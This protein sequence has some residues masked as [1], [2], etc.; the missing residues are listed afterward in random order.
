[1]SS[2]SSVLAVRARTPSG[3]SVTAI[4]PLRQ[5]SIP[6][7]ITNKNIVV[8]NGAVASPARYV[9]ADMTVNGMGGTPLPA[10]LR[11]TP[12]DTPALRWGR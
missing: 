10:R 4:Q 12:V 6:V 11:D 7:T 5:P 2:P 1:M 3:A 9:S 8:P